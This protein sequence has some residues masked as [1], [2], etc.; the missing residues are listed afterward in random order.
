V[1]TYCSLGRLALCTNRSIGPD[2]F[3]AEGLGWVLG[4]E[5]LRACD[6]RS[7]VVVVG[8]ATVVV[9]SD[10]LGSLAEVVAVVVA[11]D[12]LGSLAEVVAVVVASGRFG[13]LAEV[14]AAGFLKKLMIL[15]CF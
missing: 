4:V 9:A 11:S 13:S 15:C 6:S 2:R 3:L 1:P 12:R 8:V 5:V 7:V 10:R 14:V